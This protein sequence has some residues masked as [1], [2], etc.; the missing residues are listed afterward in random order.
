MVCVT[1]GKG[2]ARGVLSI[3]AKLGQGYVPLRQRL[4]QVGQ[5]LQAHD[6]SG[7]V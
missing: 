6:R 3:L 5:N 4:S 7:V 2:T 1:V